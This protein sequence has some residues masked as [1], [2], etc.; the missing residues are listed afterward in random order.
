MPEG[1]DLVIPLTAPAPQ[2]V[3]LRKLPTTAG[4]AARPDDPS[5]AHARAIREQSWSTTSDTPLS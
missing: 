1:V 5:P 3:R 2:L 4:G